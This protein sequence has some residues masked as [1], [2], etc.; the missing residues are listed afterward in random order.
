MLNSSQPENTDKESCHFRTASP[1]K[2]MLCGE[3]AVLCGALAIAFPTKFRQCMEVE[4]LPGS[5]N[6]HW[7]SFD[8]EGF[9]WLRCS[10]HPNDDCST[11]PLKNVLQPI[12]AMLRH[13]QQYKPDAMPADKDITFRVKASFRKEW[14]LGSS[15]ALIANIARWSGLDP[16]ELMQLSFPGSGYDVAVAFHGKS[17]V[18]RIENE[19]RN[20]RFL[21]YVPEWLNSFRVVFTG[22]KVN[23]RD[24]VNENKAMFHKLEPHV[25]EL[26]RIALG[27]LA[28]ES[29]E[30][31]CELLQ[32]YEAILAREL[33]MEPGAHLF[34]GYSGTIKSLGAWGGD[35]I[36]VEYRPDEFEKVFQNLTS[37]NFCDIIQTTSSETCT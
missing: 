8:F 26:D 12:V 19:Q 13:V 35:A 17:M 30:E 20:I 28:V 27:L 4:Y 24:S 23:S 9:Q 5:G 14:G 29:C 11:H 22:K 31:A 16:W 3:Y 34:P 1:G 15:S 33:E 7:Q 37:F 32:R 10:F 18:Y 6:I 21:D 36:L 2:I 25:E